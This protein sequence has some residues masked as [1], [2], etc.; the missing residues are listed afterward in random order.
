[1]LCFGLLKLLRN[2]LRIT[3]REQQY[4]PRDQQ[5][6]P[7][8]LRSVLRPI[9]ESMLEGIGYQ[10]APQ[11]HDKE[12][13]QAVLDA[14]HQKV[15][16]YGMTLDDPL[17]AKGFRLG[18]S[19]AALAYPDHS[20]AVQTY[21]AIF[22]WIVV[23]IDDITPSIKNEFQKRFLR[24]EEQPLPILRGLA[25]IFRE[26][27]D[28][29]DP[30]LANLLVKSV[31]FAFARQVRPAPERVRAR[32]CATPFR[33]FGHKQARGLGFVTANLLDAE[34]GFRRMQVTAAGVSFPYYFRHMSG[35]TEAYAIFTYPSGQ[36]PDLSQFLEAIPDIALFININNDVLSF[37]KEEIAGE[38]T[39]YI[40]NRAR[41]ER[42]DPLAVVREVQQEVVDCVGRVNRILEGREP[43]LQAWQVHMTGHIAMHTV[44]PRYRLAELGLGEEHP[45]R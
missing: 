7:E 25:A 38:S 4:Q 33:P 17:S 21:I 16:D 42:K 13:K 9:F 28:H 45:L 36:Y 29:W 44:N 19:E 3:S 34:E 15:A 6:Q 2:S 23:Q 24:G 43:Y 35:I 8:K 26:A 10:G 32:I 27:Y 18:F 41:C 22:T 5:L 20:V 40:H 30:V 14:M 31:S 11:L 37:Y 39:N 12:K 1:M